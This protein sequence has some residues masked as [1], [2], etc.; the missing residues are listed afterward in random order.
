M[1]ET[2]PQSWMRLT[3]SNDATSAA[4]RYASPAPTVEDTIGH[5]IDARKPFEV[6]SMPTSSCVP[7]GAS[8][9][10]TRSSALTSEVSTSTTM[11]CVGL[12]SVV[13]AVPG[14]FMPPIRETNR[15]P[16]NWPSTISESEI[17]SMPPIDFQ[18]SGRCN[19]VHTYWRGCSTTVVCVNVSVGTQGA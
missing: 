13:L 19:C 10:C 11:L 18:V 4:V 1:G 8:T 16:S 17:S 2:H 5:I 9:R 15:N 12:D 7:D 14:K 6:R 3:H